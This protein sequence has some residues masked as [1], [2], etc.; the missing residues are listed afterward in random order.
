MVT[1]A[2][3]SPDS[4]LRHGVA[5]VSHDASRTGAPLIALNIARELVEARGIPVVTILLGQGELEAEFAQMGPLFVARPPLSPA[6]YLD[7]RPW[8]RLVKRAIYINDAAWHDRFWRRI[9]NYLAKRQIR[10]AV[11]NTVLSGGAAIRL[12]GAGVASIGLVHELPHSIRANKWTDEVAALIQGVDSLVFPCPQVQAAFIGAFSTDD[13]PSYV[14][15]QSC[16]I[17]PDQL[18]VERRTAGRSAVRARLGLTCDDILILGCGGSGDF[19][20]GVDL[21]VHAAR[22]MALSSKP[23]ATR[24]IVFAWAGQIGWGFRVWAEKDV[25][26][27]ALSD[28][29]IFLGPQQDM[30]PCFAAADIF[31]LP[32]R[33][34]PFPTTVLEAMAYG[35]PIVG[36]AGSGGLEEQICGGGGVI[37]PY[38][39]V[40]SAVKTLHQLAGQPDERNRMGRLGR[41]KIALSGGYH[42]YVGNLVDVVLGSAS[43]KVCLKRSGQ[44]ALCE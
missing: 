43:S 15:P 44:A 34:D 41:E 31:F 20:K 35:L 39:D 9:S 30:A 36:F 3:C 5:I 8:A 4:K 38:G 37:V 19:R 26:E 33:E 14:H 18:T 22:Q 2:K 21:F 12:K 6:Y 13:K 28:R 23:S 10:H 32:S 24:K 1:H 42:A 27:L 16:N 40:T 25:T 11:C 29:L 17:N 7:T